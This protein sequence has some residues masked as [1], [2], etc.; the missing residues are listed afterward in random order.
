V[1]W[2]AVG[3]IAS[4]GG[5]VAVIV[6]VIYLAAQVRQNTRQV[7]EQVRAHHLESLSAVATKFSAFRLAVAGT[8]ELA[9]IWLRGNARLSALSATDRLRF[10]YLAVD[11]LRSLSMMA[12]FVTQGVLE[13]SLFEHSSRNAEF[14][15]GPGF[16]EWWQTSPHRAEFD[17]SFIHRMDV[18]LGA[19]PAAFPGAGLP[20]AGDPTAVH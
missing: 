2:T 8:N 10:D 20:S 17:A 3:V 6:S 15:V 13:P 9:D 5:T 19:I 11:F 14:Y 12:T 7:Q 18:V 4:L 16:R 1:D